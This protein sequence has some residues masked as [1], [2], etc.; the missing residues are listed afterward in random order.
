LVDFGFPLNVVQ[1][2]KEMV[3]KILAMQLLNKYLE[4][5]ITLSE[6]YL[7]GLQTVLEEEEDAMKVDTKGKSIADGSISA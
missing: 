3:S 6:E 1:A 5:A 4:K 2:R 7:G